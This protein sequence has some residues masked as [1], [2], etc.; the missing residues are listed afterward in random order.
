MA[1]LPWL[2][3]HRPGKVPAQVQC[4]PSL[5]RDVETRPCIPT[6]SFPDIPSLVAG[7]LFLSCLSLFFSL[8]YSIALS[9]YASSDTVQSIARFYRLGNPPV[10]FVSFVLSQSQ[11]AERRISNLH[12]FHDCTTSVSLSYSTVPTEPKLHNNSFH[13]TLL[14]LIRYIIMSDTFRDADHASEA[15]LDPELLYSKEYCIGRSPLL[16]PALDHSVC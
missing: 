1:Q 10:S 7:L 3:V 9:V 12:S 13:V 6:I 14:F 2:V 11:F 4:T 16:V 15:L 5:P 8:L